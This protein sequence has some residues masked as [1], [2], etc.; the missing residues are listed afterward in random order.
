VTGRA[1]RSRIV[2]VGSVVAGGGDNDDAA[3]AR[4]DDL[5]L[6]RRIEGRSPEAHVHDFRAMADGKAQTRDDRSRGSAA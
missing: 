1:R 6:K 2:V 3:I 4:I 5:A